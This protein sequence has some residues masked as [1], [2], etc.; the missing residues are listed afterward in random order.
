VS[1]K[2]GLFFEPDPE[3]SPASELTWE[4]HGDTFS[5]GIA[6]AGAHGEISF[7]PI[8]ASVDMIT[9][10]KHTSLVEIEFGVMG[11]DFLVHIT[12]LHGQKNLTKPHVFQAAMTDVVKIMNEYVP[13]DLQVDIFL[14]RQDYEIKATSFKIRGGNDAWNFDV[15]TFKVEAIQRILDTVTEHCLKG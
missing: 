6:E 10:K 15:A 12:P 5:S 14:P 13:T 3:A 7:A 1:K 4:E 9:E 11:N 8:E 2:G